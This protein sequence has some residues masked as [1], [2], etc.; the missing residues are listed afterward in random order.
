MAVYTL[1]LRSF[2]TITSSH[3]LQ[4]EACLEGSDNDSCLF[5]GYSLSYQVKTHYPFSVLLICM[6]ASQTHFLLTVS[7]SSLALIRMDGGKESSL[8]LPMFF[9]SL[10]TSC[11]CLNYFPLRR[12]PTDSQVLPSGIF[13]LFSC[14]NVTIVIIDTI[15][16]IVYFNIYLYEYS[17][18]YSLLSKP[19][20]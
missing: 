8:A 19:F 17:C 18:R 9:L 15:V 13:C 3:H 14:N 16:N 6:K 5:P 2:G 12:T 11:R 10:L 4:L 1:F 7:K 20:V